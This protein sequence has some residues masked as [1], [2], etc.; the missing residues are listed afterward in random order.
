ML[1]PNM[2]SGGALSESAT[3]TDWE[4]RG[5]H[6]RVNLADGHAH[7]RL[8]YLIDEA[9]VA[10]QETFDTRRIVLQDSLELHFRDALLALGGQSAPVRPPSLHYSSST[11]IDMTAKTLAAA[12][13]RRVGVLTPTFDNI[14]QLLQRV[15]LELIPLAEDTVRGAPESWIAQI[16]SVDAVFLVLP[17]NPTGWCPDEAWFEAL[18]AAAAHKRIAVAI[19]FSFRFM[20]PGLATFDQ[21]G[22]AEGR[23]NLDWIFIEDTGKTWA[24][25]ELKVGMASCSRGLSRTMS[26]VSGELLLNVP[27]FTVVLLTNLI[28][29]DHESIRRGGDLYVRETVRRN[30]AV[31]RHELGASGREM[32]AA[33]DSTISVEWLRLRVREAVEVANALAERGVSILPGGPFFWDDRAKGAHY[34]RVALARQAELFPA[35]ARDLANGLSELDS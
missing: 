11:T 31:L 23:T 21:Y 14:A 30:R 2:N 4:W 6:N 12:G 10:L 32:V 8:P 25:G 3:L 35:A 7:F 19:D 1:S 5:L 27:P 9:I 17:N 18:F 16:G 34:V 13:A 24:T 29:R 15:S 26:E 33:P 22:Q 28:E 20:A